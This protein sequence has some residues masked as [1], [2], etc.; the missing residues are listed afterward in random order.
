MPPRSPNSLQRHR[1][2]EAGSVD[3]SPQ[4]GR[5]PFERLDVDPLGRMDGEASPQR[6]C[7][8]LPFDRVAV[9]LLAAIR[10]ASRSAA[11]CVQLRTRGCHGGRAFGAATTFGLVSSAH[12]LAA[13]PRAWTFRCRCGWPHHHDSA[14][15]HARQCAFD[16]ALDGGLQATWVAS[17]RSRL[18]VVG[19]DDLEGSLISIRHH[20]KSQPAAA[21]AGRGAWPPASESQAIVRARVGAPPPGGTASPAGQADG[22]VAAHRREFAAEEGRGPVL[23]RLQAD[24]RVLD[25]IQMRINLVSAP[26]STVRRAAL[27]SPTPAT[28]GY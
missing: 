20:R 13:C 27:F 21:G 18:T 16:F 3:R 11:T 19:D 24:P 10:R 2:R 25:G 12:Q 17:R 22:H 5:G 6:I 1:A 14:P 4:Q 15:G 23:R 7:D 26:N 9:N 28:R 8:R